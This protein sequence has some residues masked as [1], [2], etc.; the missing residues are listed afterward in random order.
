MNTI[1]HNN[2]ELIIRGLS[3]VYGTLTDNT[4]SV[5]DTI[6]RFH[7]DVCMILVQAVESGDESQIR[8]A[9]NTAIHSI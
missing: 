2:G 4:M 8:E 9:Y 6:I 5:I 1:V 7:D 3:S